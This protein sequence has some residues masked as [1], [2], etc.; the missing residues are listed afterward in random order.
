MYLITNDLISQFTLAIL[1]NPYIHY[2]VN[3]IEQ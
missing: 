3:R 1:C 2:G